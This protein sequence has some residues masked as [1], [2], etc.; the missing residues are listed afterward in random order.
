MPKSATHDVPP[1]LPHT[2][3]EKA[4]LCDGLLPFLHGLKEAVWSATGRR[5]D[6][7]GPARSVM[8]Q[9]LLADVRRL[10]R[11]ERMAHYLSGLTIS[12]DTAGRF[13][14]PSSSR[15]SKPRPRPFAPAISAG[16][17]C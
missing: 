16:T 14:W 6:A 3:V 15:R 4:A 5:P 2:T 8:A 10:V 9:L 17:R 13:G 7:P 12:D 11:G 1:S